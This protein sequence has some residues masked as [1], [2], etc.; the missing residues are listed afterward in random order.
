MDVRHRG[1]DGLRIEAQLDRGLLELVGEHV[2]QHLRVRAGV[3]VAVG[4]EHLVLELLG[5]RQVAVMAEDDAEGRVDVERLRLGALNAE[6]AV[7]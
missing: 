7:G 1:K 3:D 2:D 4:A 6:P 5:V